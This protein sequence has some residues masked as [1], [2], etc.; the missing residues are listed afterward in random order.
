MEH[1]LSTLDGARREVKISLTSDEL[2]PH[3]EEAYKRAQ[4][5]IA[6]D[7]FRKGKVPISVIKKRFGR[8]IE[9]EALETIADEEF[10][11]YATAEKLRVVGHPGLTDIDKQK[12]GVTFTISFEVMPEIELGD[13]RG[14]EVNRPV[15]EV[16]EKDV[17]EELDRI[18]LRAAT[19]E[20]AEE[21]KDNM[22]VATITLRELDKESGVPVIGTEPQEQRVFLDDDQAD[23]HLRNSLM[24]KKVGDEFNYTGETQ[25]ENE[26]PPSYQVTVSDIQKVVP[27]ELTNDFAETIT[28]GKITSTEELREDIE[29]SAEGLLRASVKECS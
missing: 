5:G 15:R 2:K 25:E 18:R 26:A 17:E 21:V 1:T 4:S 23:M 3:Y 8:E 7:G 13:Y 24:E 16:S 20:P 12:E 14:L 9:A 27:A 28:G 29:D 6:L 22:H 19:F 11:S 10:R